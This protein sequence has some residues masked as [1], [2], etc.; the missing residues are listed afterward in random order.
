MSSAPKNDSRGETFGKRE[1][2]DKS[3][4][5]GKSAEKVINLIN[6]IGGRLCKIN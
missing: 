4:T 1:R 6:R 3:N 2:K 5:F